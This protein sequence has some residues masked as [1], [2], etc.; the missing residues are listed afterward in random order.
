MSALAIALGGALGAL[1][2]WALSRFITT[3][4][5]TAFPLGTLFVNLLGCFFFGVV[6]GFLARRLELRSEVSLFLLTGFMGSFTTFSTYAHDTLN[7]WRT[8]G[9]LASSGNILA[10]TVLGILFVYAGLWVTN[11]A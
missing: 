1:S 5:S 6:A 11:R 8:E 3:R 10:Q 7:L 4:L 9:F 2:R